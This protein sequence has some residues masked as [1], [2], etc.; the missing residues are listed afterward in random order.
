M[1]FDA[2][3]QAA[4]ADLSKV[5]VRVG[6]PAWGSDYVIYSGGTIIGN[7]FAGAQPVS[8]QKDGTFVVHGL[9]P[10]QYTFYPILA[11]DVAKAFWLRSAVV[12]GTDVLDSVLE[13]RGGVDLTDVVLTFSDRHTELTGRLTTQAGEP[14]PE[15]YVVVLPAD[16]TLWRA[17]ARRVKTTRPSTDG[18]FTI[19]DLPAGDYLIAALTDVAPN[20]W[21]DVR[22][23]AQV[24]PL[25]V[26]FTLGEGEKKR[27]DLR[28]AKW[29]P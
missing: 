25:G 15:Y 29:R 22:F 26:P 11:A 2:T 18:T 16:K 14:A 20:E 23:L 10:G 17:N 19:R 24:A 12:D 8:A 5:L 21:N 13:A 3:T 4:P 28:I 27:Q 7:A 1:V 6:P 9:A